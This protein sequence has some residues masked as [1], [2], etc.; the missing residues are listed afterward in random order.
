MYKD[1]NVGVLAEVGD[2]FIFRAVKA[3]FEFVRGKEQD[4]VSLI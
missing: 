2:V 1:E 4:W 3:Y